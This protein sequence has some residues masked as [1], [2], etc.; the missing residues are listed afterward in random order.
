MMAGVA[1]KAF[2][3]RYNVFNTQSFQLEDNWVAL[4]GA[5]SLHQ[6]RCTNFKSAF[7]ACK[8]SK[9]AH[10]VCKHPLWRKRCACAVVALLHVVYSGP[11]QAQ[12]ASAIHTP[13][14]GHS[15]RANLRSGPINALALAPN[16]DLIFR[17]YR[18]SVERRTDRRRP[19]CDS[20]TLP[21]GR[22]GGPRCAPGGWATRPSAVE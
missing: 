15:V 22:L 13:P 14:K 5:A 10:K 3:K 6:R 19:E 1:R 21:E 12:S 17:L 11:A 7:G 2:A 9:A 8:Y 20:I 18:L 4:R 16:R